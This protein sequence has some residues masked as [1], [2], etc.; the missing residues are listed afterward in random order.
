MATFK[1]GDREL[2]V[3]QASLRIWRDVW[4]PYRRD[5]AN[6]DESTVD[7]QEKM[8]ERIVKFL[9]DL[10]GPTNKDLTSAWLTDNMPFPIPL[11]EILE[12]AG[13]RKKEIGAG[14]SKSQQ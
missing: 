5:V 1:I 6:I 9:G 4:N 7:G 8:A 2:N 13:F 3:P 12:L 10:L 11:A 14:E